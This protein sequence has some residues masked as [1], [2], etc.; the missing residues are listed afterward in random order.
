[1]PILHSHSKLYR[2][3][4]G[5]CVPGNPFQSPNPASVLLRLGPWPERHQ[6]RVFIIVVNAQHGSARKA[7]LRLN[8]LSPNLQTELSPPQAIEEWQNPDK[9]TVLP[10]QCSAIPEINADFLTQVVKTKRAKNLLFSSSSVPM[11]DDY[12]CACF[13]M[14]AWHV[15]TP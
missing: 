10:L 1:M 2:N 9:A 6:G 3:R 11:P 14:Y 4:P 5:Q 7:L 15:Y 12:I 13:H 8:S